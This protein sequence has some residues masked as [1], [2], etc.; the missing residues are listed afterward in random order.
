MRSCGKFLY[1]DSMWQT[2]WLSQCKCTHP[3]VTEQPLHSP[4]SAAC[5]VGTAAVMAS[6]VQAQRCQCNF[7]HVL[8]YTISFWNSLQCLLSKSCHFFPQ[9]NN[10]NKNSEELRAGAC[11]IFWYSQ[12]GCQIL[13]RA[14]I[15]LSRG[16]RKI[17]NQHEA[18]CTLVRHV[19]NWIYYSLY[20]KRLR[21]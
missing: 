20:F 5:E 1:L 6:H 7:H 3:P 10:L 14:F 11:H 17:L 13:S 4:S 12:T 2:E 18:G 21:A 15:S 9:N 16:R 8:I 19:F